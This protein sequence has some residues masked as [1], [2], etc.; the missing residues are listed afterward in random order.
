[1]YFPVYITDTALEVRNMTEFKMTDGDL[2]LSFRAL[3]KTGAFQYIT[4]VCD[5]LRRP[6]E[7]QTLKLCSHPA[8]LQLPAA[9]TELHVPT[10][11][12]SYIQ[13]LQWFLL[14]A[15]VFI[16]EGKK[17]E[18]FKRLLEHLHIG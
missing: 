11:Y 17:T 18:K 16:K 14:D 13:G 10:E 6:V 4:I 2:E 3:V 9:A 8:L 7:K 15:R 5:D 1:M 12:R